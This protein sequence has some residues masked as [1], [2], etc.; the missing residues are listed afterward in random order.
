[1]GV[2]VARLARQ[3]PRPLGVSGVGSGAGTD[4]ACDNLHTQEAGA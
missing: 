4:A 3:R 2:V 1:M